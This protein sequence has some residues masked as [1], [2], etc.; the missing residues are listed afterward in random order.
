MKKGDSREDSFDRRGDDITNVVQRERL[1]EIPGEMTST[2]DYARQEYAKRDFNAAI[3]IERCAVLKKRPAE[4]TRA[5]FVGQSLRVEMYK[6]KLNPVA[7][8]QSREASRCLRASMNL[9]GGGKFF[10]LVAKMGMQCSP[11]VEGYHSF[12]PLTP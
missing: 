11:T 7:G 3:N 9:P 12:V 1:P 4:L 2:N 5:N 10:V 8:S 6:K